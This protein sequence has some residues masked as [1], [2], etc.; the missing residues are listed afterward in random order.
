MNSFHLRF[1]FGFCLFCIFFSFI[2]VFEIFFHWNNNN[3]K[4]RRK[5]TPG[6]NCTINFYRFISQN[7]VYTKQI[8]IILWCFTT[9]W[10]G[11]VSRTLWPYGK[12]QSAIGNIDKTMRQIRN[13]KWPT[14]WSIEVWWNWFINSSSEWMIDGYACAP[15]AVSLQLTIPLVRLLCSWMCLP[16]LI[17]T[18]ARWSLIH[19]IFQMPTD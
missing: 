13:N 6:V 7:H 16:I 12:R 17:T 5:K 3:N 2:S 10:H 15:N 4:R 1:V 9:W 19:F 14:G 18:V 11:F 8:N